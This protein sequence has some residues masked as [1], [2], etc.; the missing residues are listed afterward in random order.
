VITSLG[1]PPGIFKEFT[2]TQKKDEL[3]T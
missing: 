3:V 2:K 1:N